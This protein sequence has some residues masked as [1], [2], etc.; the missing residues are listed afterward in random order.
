MLMALKK[1]S[2]LNKVDYDEI[3]RR[4]N[5]SVGEKISHL[6]TKSEFYEKMDEVLGEVKAMRE[7]FAA[8][9]STHEDLDKDV[10]NLQHKV[11]HLYK[12]FEIEEPADVIPA[13]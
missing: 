10:P 4:I 11:K 5:E 1:G 8:H 12:V 7:D 9:K 2:V 6:P 13:Y 3:D